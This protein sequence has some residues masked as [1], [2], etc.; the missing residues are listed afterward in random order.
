MSFFSRDIYYFS[1]AATDQKKNFSF[2]AYWCSFTLNL[3]IFVPS[4]I[5][6][7]ATARKHFGMGT[8]ETS[9]TVAPSGKTLALE[10]YQKKL[11]LQL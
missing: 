10:H 5:S 4:H 8:E 11:E 6:I 3:K 7:F 2:F 1:S 9:R